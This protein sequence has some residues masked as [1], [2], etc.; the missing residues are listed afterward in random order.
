MQEGETGEEINDLVARALRCL[1][2][3]EYDNRIL[4][5]ETEAWGEVPA[6]YGRK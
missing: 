4:K 6:D 5:W 3:N 2:E 1:H